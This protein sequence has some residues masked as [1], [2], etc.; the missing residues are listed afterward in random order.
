MRQW[1]EPEPLRGASSGAAAA[2]ESL[3][4]SVVGS[5]D[6]FWWYYGYRILLR[7]GDDAVVV[8]GVA[9]VGFHGHA[10]LCFLS[11]SLGLRPGHERQTNLDHGDSVQWD[12]ALY[13]TDSRLNESRTRRARMLYW[14]LREGKV[15]WVRRRRAIEWFEETEQ[16]QDVG[17][18]RSSFASLAVAGETESMQV[19]SCTRRKLKREDKS[20]GSG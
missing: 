7:Y 15:Q 16:L 10:K 8:L 4:P 3:K 17:A 5:T 14:W 19:Q 20:R 6:L 11:Q 1:S 13:S 2:I 9:L 12:S 18:V